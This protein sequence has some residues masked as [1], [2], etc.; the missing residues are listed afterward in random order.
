MFQFWAT[1]FMVA[2]VVVFFIAWTRSLKVKD[3]VPAPAAKAEWDLYRTLVL[4]AIIAQLL[5]VIIGLIGLQRTFSYLSAV[6]IAYFSVVYYFSVR[7]MLGV[8][9]EGVPKMERESGRALADVQ[10]CL[11][12]IRTTG[13]SLQTADHPED[14]RD[15]AGQI[16]ASSPNSSQSPRAHKQGNF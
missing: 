12:V 3:L 1:I 8:L 15:A 4:V 2:A 7:F 14:V 11:T 9:G 6:F 13:E 16:L 5:L 10:D